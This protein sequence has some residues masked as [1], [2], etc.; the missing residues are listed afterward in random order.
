MSE[1][2]QRLRANRPLQGR[3]CGWCG[4]PLDF[5]DPAAVCTACS[6]ATHAV[7][8]DR[9][10]GCPTADC[11]HRPLARLDQPAGAAALAE[12]Q[13][14]FAAQAAAP[15]A[16]GSETETLYEPGAPLDLD[17]M[18]CPHCGFMIAADSTLCS[19]CNMVPTADGIY[20]GP[21]TNAPGA[22]ASLVFGILAFFICGII[23]GLV[24]I[25]KANDA[26]KAIAADPRLG[27]EG[28]ATTGRILG[29]LAL[30]L[31]GVMLLARIGGMAN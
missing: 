24:A 12:A 15:A 8:W 16:A 5:G 18:K 22:V 1:S 21:K 19:Y 28:L 31:W 10:G 4:V 17:R 26:K 14:G 9:Q 3:A 25:S 30:V 6:T 13:G 11:V 20:R 7:C 27:G 29:I 23:F 2:V